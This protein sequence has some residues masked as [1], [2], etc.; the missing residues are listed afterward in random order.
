ME[1]IVDFCRRHGR[2]SLKAGIV[3]AC[4]LGTAAVFLP[5]DRSEAG[6]SASSLWFNDCMKKEVA[7]KKMFCSALN[8]YFIKVVKGGN[9]T[10]RGCTSYMA[11]KG[12]GKGTV[13]K[14]M[15]Y[16]Y[17]TDK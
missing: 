3:L 13:A 14:N 6:I 15:C 9:P 11:S 5:A 10:G 2:A 12:F 7:N 8:Q 1:R 17:F 16:W 4:V